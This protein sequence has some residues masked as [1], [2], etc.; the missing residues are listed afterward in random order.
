MRQ[1]MSYDFSWN[2]PGR[3]YVSVYEWVRHK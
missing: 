2:R 1:G 3:D